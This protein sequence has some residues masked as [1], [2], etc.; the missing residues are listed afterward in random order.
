M[1]DNSKI[2]PHKDGI[3]HINI[4]SRGKTEVGRQLSN[5][6]HTPFTHKDYGY[7][8]SV[9]GL[10][11]YLITGCKHENLS[12]MRRKPSPNRAGI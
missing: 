10:W 1:V 2:N 5:F 6:A 8:N 9:E 11:Y 7:F 12:K 4:Y 3:D